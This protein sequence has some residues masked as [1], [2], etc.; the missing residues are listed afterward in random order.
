MKKNNSVAAIIPAYNEARTVGRVVRA[1]KSVPAV[2]EVIV[3]DDGSYDKTHAMAEGAGARVITVRPNQGKGKAMSVGASLTDAKIILFVDA[4]FINLTPA[5]IEKILKPVLNNE[6]DMVTGMV[7]RGKS[8]NKIMG[9]IEDPFAG[10]RALRRDIWDKTP[11]EFKDGYVVD[12]GLHVTASRADKRIKNIVLE[13]LKQIT[14]TKKH[15][16]IKGTF[17]YI[18][19]WAEIAVKAIQFI[20]IK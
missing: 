14:K 15:G 17:L 19:M 4:D 16:V 5:H 6:Y 8:I 7:G 10:L 12:S 20:W 9:S 3:V 11:Q 13:N 1:I 2:S 18:K